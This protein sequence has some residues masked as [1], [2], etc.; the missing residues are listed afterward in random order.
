MTAPS[1]TAMESRPVR[2]RLR[3]PRHVAL[4]LAL[5]WLIV[6]VFAAAFADI[7]PIEHYEVATDEIRTGPALAWPEP[8]G[9]DQYGRSELSRVIFG[10]RN[11]LMIALFSVL[12]ALVAGTGLGMVWGYFRHSAFAVLASV[13]TDAMLAYPALI[14]LL[15]LVTIL[16]RETEYLVLTLALVLVP[17]FARLARASTL[18]FASRNYVKAALTLGSS[19]RRVLVREILPS[20]TIPVVSYAFVVAAVVIV[21]EGSLS[22]LGLGVP[23]PKPSWGQMIAEGR[24]DLATEPYLVFIPGLAMFL[25]VLALNIVGDWATRGLD[26]RRSAIVFSK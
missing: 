9:T 1:G 5:S 21:A 20:I 15:A 14:L 22:F 8:L 19:V 23:P 25:T 2:A 4:W 24:P 17:T 12:L 26:V 18:S 16:P 3:R 11:S 7:L 10:A 6:I 13:V